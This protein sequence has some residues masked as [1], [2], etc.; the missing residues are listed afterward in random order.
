[1]SA[2]ET[3]GRAPA[4]PRGDLPAADHLRRRDRLRA[5]LADHG[6][7][8][9]LVTAPANVRWLSGFAGSNGQVLVGAD[10][11]TDRLVTDARYEERAATESPGLAVA[12]SRDPFAVA[13]DGAASGAVLGIEAE[14][15]PWAQAQRWCERADEAGIE[16]RPT[17]PVV[18]GLRVVKDD[19]ELARLEAACAFT[20]DALAWLFAEVV[21]EGRTE[22]ELATALERRF[23][24]LGADG[25]A[26]ASI[27]A[28]GPNASVPHHAPTERPLRPGDLLTVDCGALV[29]GYHAD[30][31]RTVALGHLDHQLVRVHSAVEA[32]QARGRAAAVAGASA[33]DV[34]AACRDLLDDLG[35]GDHFVHGTGHGVGL[36]IHEAPA[37]AKGSAATL[38]AAMALTVEPG[39]YLPGVG[40]VRIEDTIVVTADGPPSI[41]TTAPRELRIL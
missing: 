32:A 5:A 4:G 27:V 22:R 26:F 41:L 11:N 35:Y 3:N 8:A 23:V 25:V 18:E 12:L 34:D 33:G 14:H 19:A 28:S 16:V 1:M 2:A 38:S 30:C 13:L 37:V 9:L 7:E 29:D 39:V 21:A 31:T 10:A 20:V 6:V 36:D 15:V 24:D 17:A 40:G